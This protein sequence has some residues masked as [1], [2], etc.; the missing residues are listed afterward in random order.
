MLM[1]GFTISKTHKTT[2]GREAKEKEVEKVVVAAVALS[3]TYITMAALLL[4]F[5]EKKC[6]C[7]EFF[8]FAG[9]NLELVV[10]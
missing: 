8:L 6:A 1:V 5:F 2:K 10:S 9:V 4:L 7:K 3:T